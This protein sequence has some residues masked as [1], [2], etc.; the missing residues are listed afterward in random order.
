MLYRQT[1]FYYGFNNGR[2]EMLDK[3]LISMTKGKILSSMSR[4]I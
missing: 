3:Q 1:K 4:D 2:K